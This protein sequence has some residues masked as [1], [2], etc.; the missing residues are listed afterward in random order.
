M[1][2]SN[3]F[4]RK[5]TQAER[6]TPECEQRILYHMEQA[7]SKVVWQLPDDFDTRDA[8]DRVLERLDMQS[9]PG[10]PYM[11]EATTNG[12]WLEWNGVEMSKRKVDRLWHDVQQVVNDEWEQ[13]LRVFIK[14]EPHKLTKVRDGRWRLIMAASLPVQVFW[15]MLFSYMNDLE[16]EESYVIPSQQGIVLVNGNWK[17]YK[18]Q[19]DYHGLT[20]GLDKS[21]WDWTAP[22]WTLKLDLIFRYRMGRGDRLLEWLKHAQLAYYYMFSEPTLLLSDG[23][24]L[25]QVVPGIMKSGCVNTISTNSHCQLF[26][27]MAVCFDKGW[28][29]HPLPRAC[30]DD[31]LQHVKHTTDVQAYEKYGVVIKEVSETAEFVGHTFTDHGPV[32]NYWFKHLKKLLWQK[33][34]FMGQYLD[35]MARMYVHTDYYIFWERIARCLG[36]PLPLSR[37]AYKYWY[38]YEEF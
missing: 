11:R 16:I 34:E 15:H 12:Q 27:H 4:F 32:P 17:D 7:Y 5:S 26:I 3:L 8:F 23:T 20:C 25:R 29:I 18:R 2:H 30:G 28:D 35:S 21:S 10:Y 33:D 9:S 14:Q 38:D 6:P 13:V 31:T 24:C 37:A 22:F 36:E 1:V 19:W